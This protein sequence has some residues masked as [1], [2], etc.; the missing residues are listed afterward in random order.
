MTTEEALAQLR[1]MVAADTPPELTDPELAA[2]L[3]YAAVP[4]AAGREPAHPDWTPTYDL[5]RLRASAAEG[6]RRKA[7]KASTMVDIT[8]D[9]ASVKRSQIQ[10]HALAMAASFGR[11]GDGIG[12]L[13]TTRPMRGLGGHP[14]RDLNAL[15]VGNAPEPDIDDDLDLGAGGA[16]TWPGYGRYR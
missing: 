15:P 16:G 5:M 4:D 14:R 2:L 6:W 8:A 7:A 9:D 1:G 12:R 13:G 10:D 3:V 11:N